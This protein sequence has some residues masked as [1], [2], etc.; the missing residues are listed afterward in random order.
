MTRPIDE[1]SWLLNHPQFEERPATLTEF[2]GAD[3]LNIEDKVRA[4]IRNVLADIFG[5]E[6]GTENPSKFMRALFT[7]GIGIGKTTVASICLTYLVHWTLCLKD[8]QDFFDLIPGSRIAFVMMSTSER[9][10]KDVIFGDV[11]ERI[12]HSPWFKRYPFDP[13]FR[14]RFEFPKYVVILPL[15]SEEIAAEGMNVLGGVIDEIDSGKVTDRKIY[16]QTAYETI[17]NR[18]DSRYGDKGLIFLIGQRKSQS[19]FAQTMLD[20]FQE[21]DD[22][23]AHVMTIWESRGVDYYEAEDGS[24]LLFHYDLSRK[25]F[26]PQGVIDEGLIDPA[27]PSVLSVP[28]MYRKAFELNPEKALKDL[29]GIPPA[30]GDPFIS[31]AHKI[32][33]CRDRWVEEFGDD[34][35]VNKDG[36]FR[37]DWK[38]T[39]SVPRVA[40]IDVGFSGDGDALGLAMGHVRRMVE[41]DGELKPYIVFDFLYQKTVPSGHEIFLGD[42]RHLVYDLKEHFKFKISQVS[43]DGFQ[44]QDTIQQFNRRRIQSCYL[45]VDKEKLPYY[46]LREAIYEGRVAFPPYIVRSKYDD[47]KDVEIAVQELSELTDEGKKI[48]HPSTGSKDVAD[49][50]AGVTFTLMGDRRFHRK[51]VS[52]SGYRQQRV[53]GDSTLHPAYLGDEGIHAP[54]PP[55]GTFSSPKGV[56]SPW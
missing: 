27:Q 9:Q 49:A 47:T 23:Y 39:D 10:A 48:D 21:R 35:I 52:M 2:L 56:Q 46:D 38:S 18:I 34:P 53:S 55:T 6:V 17:E 41:I 33:E 5:E 3:Y 24:N 45:S 20:D 4:E 19:G 12:L 54:R 29:A 26:I 31:Y 40:H 28:V 15:G 43:L 25:E 7:G 13:K 32:L 44:S 50:M 11:K 16:M 1:I 42:V 14:T 37:K 30:V 36:Q 8:P 22:A 51:V